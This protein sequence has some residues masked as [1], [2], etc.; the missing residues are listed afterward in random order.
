[1]D[2]R[3]CLQ[4]HKSTWKCCKQKCVGYVGTTGYWVPSFME[5]RVNEDMRYYISQHYV[6]FY[7]WNIHKQ[8][9]KDSLH[10]FLLYVYL[11]HMRHTSVI[12]R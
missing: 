9:L 12:L 8:I 2:S 5:S 6:Y 4:M 7:L 10:D 3:E 1:M 11:L